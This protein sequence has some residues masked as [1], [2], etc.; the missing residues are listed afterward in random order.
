MKND[1]IC[2]VIVTHNRREDF[3]ELIRSIKKYHDIFVFYNVDII[4]FDNESDI[5]VEKDPLYTLH[6]SNNQRKTNGLTGAWEIVVQKYINSYKYFIF[7]NHDVVLD[8]SIE[9][10]FKCLH[11]LNG[12]FVLGPSSNPGG[13]N[14]YQ[15]R[16]QRCTNR[17]TKCET[18]EK[19]PKTPP[20]IHGFFWATNR[21]SLIT[22]MHNDNYYFNPSFPFG[23]CEDDWQLRLIE[24]DQ[25]TKLLW[26]KSCYV[27][28]K[29]HSDWRNKAD[30]QG[31]YNKVYEEDTGYAKPHQAKIDYVVGWCEQAGS[32]L[33]TGCGRGEYIRAVAP[34]VCSVTGVE[35]SKVCCD[36]YLSDVNYFNEDIVT[37]CKRDIRYDAVYCTDVLEHIPPL[38]LDEVLE[39]LSSVSDHFLFLV[40][41]G[42]DKKCGYELHLSNFNFEEWTSILGERFKITKSIKGFDQWPYIHIF[43]CENK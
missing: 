9:Q 30:E 24:R 4:V 3:L 26:E 10:F 11:S 1:K 5:P 12:S 14:Q 13:A 34:H 32:I 29:H 22:A 16:M 31:V 40:A 25:S 21:N 19:L 37:Y 6:K 28:H 39:C 23:G 42:S 35:I 15:S 2:F 27:Y 38:C 18:V 17:N 41:S 7:S 8:Q 33:D 20:M 43:E 36:K